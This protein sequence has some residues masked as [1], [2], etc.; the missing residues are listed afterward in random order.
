MAGLHPGLKSWGAMV[1]DEPPGHQ[2]LKGN[3]APVLEEVTVD[4]LKV[5]GTIPK[6]L[7]GMYVRNGPN[8]LIR[9]KGAYHWFEGDGMLH[10]VSLHEGKASYRNRFI[11]TEGYKNEKAA[12][13]KLYTSLMEMPDMKEMMK[14]KNPYKNAGNTAL[15]WHAKKF[16]TLYEGGKPHSVKLPSLE[17]EGEYDFG[18]KLKANFTAHPKVDPVTGE[19][20][21]FAYSHQPVALFYQIAKDGTWQ[22]TTP[23]KLQ[24]PSMMH[25]FAVTPNYAVFYELPETF[26]LSRAFTGK[27]PWYF[28][29]ARQSRFGIVAR[30]PG[31]DGK[32]EVKWFESKPCFI[33]HTLNAYEEGDNVIVLACRYPRF[34]GSIDGEKGGDK[35]VAVLYRY[36]FNLKT[37]K[38]SEGPVDDAPT[39]FPRVN[40]AK[41]MRST[42]FGYTGTG[43]GDF[44]SSMLKYELATGKK[45]THDYGPGRFGGEGVFVARAGSKDEDDG[46]LLNYV[47]DQAENKSELVIIAAQDFTGK[48]EARVLLPV[49]VPYGFHG[50]WVERGE[51]A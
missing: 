34:P 39:E 12:G 33:F 9:P 18:K 29:A 8:P 19:M 37:G 17:T 25:D 28:D 20:V 21:G 36:A 49:R 5:V 30:R 11:Q 1:D 24:K 14:G 47:Y 40:D 13:K 35:N 38:I 50:A 42:K 6:E 2:F 43:E 32:R 48:P 3:F 26:E 7:D 10:G 22:T 4:Q 46:W 31:A 27:P 51:Y 16:L 41:A 23:I 15:V 44:F 45:Q